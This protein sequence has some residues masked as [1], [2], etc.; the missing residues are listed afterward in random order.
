MRGYSDCMLS[1]RSQFY[2][3]RQ[4]QTS[5]AA[6]LQMLHNN[7]VER[8]IMP[9]WIRKSALL[10]TCM[11]LHGTCVDVCKQQSYSMS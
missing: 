5:P 4:Q 7:V 6:Q 11:T 2:T 9:T 10:T 3:Y 1:S 8:S